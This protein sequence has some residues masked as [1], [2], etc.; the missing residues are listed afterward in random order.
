MMKHALILIFALSPLTYSCNKIV[1]K[2]KEDIVISAITNGHWFVKEYRAGALYVTAEFDGYEFQFYTDGKVDGILNTTVTNGTWTGD[3]N[4][5]TITS[6]FS[7]ASQPLSRL[8]GM[9]KITDNSYTNVSAYNVNGADTN[10][11]ELQKK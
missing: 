7:G 4:L 6:N 3:V 5:M 11:L 1:E 8:N 2:K 10:F 9:W